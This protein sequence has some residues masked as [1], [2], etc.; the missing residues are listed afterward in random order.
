MIKTIKSWL[1]A[2][3][4]YPNL[5]A[6]FDF[7]HKEYGWAMAE[8]KKRTDDLTKTGKEL[9]RLKKVKAKQTQEKKF[10]KIWNNK[11]PRLK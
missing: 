10:E 7:L 6:A 1:E 2:I 8:L 5:K 11:R 9:A 4:E 3:R